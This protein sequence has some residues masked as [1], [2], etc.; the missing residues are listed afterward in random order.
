MT[1]EGRKAIA[2]LLGV[3]P[4]R[5]RRLL[6]AHPEMPVVV[7]GDTQ[8]GRRYL[9]DDE[10]LGAWRRRWLGSLGHTGAH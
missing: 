5:L 10:L 3:T 4:K 2:E 6:R 1:L 7:E 9:A 8:Q